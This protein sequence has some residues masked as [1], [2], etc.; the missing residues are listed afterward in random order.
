MARYLMQIEQPFQLYRVSTFEQE[1][2]NKKKNT[3]KKEKQNQN[4][5]N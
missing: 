2:K 4:T 3:H 1:N 5:M